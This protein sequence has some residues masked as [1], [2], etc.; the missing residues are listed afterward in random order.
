MPRKRSR[1]LTDAEARIMNVLW[2]LQR[3][4]VGEVVEALPAG[5]APAYNTI[6]TLLRIL[7][8]KGYVAHEKEGRAFIY[9]PLVD[10]RAARQGAIRHLVARLFDG[11]PRL[12]LLNLLE[13][14][15]LDSAELDRLKKL[16]EAR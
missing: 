16:I 8:H 10:R 12:L 15:R 7:E 1:T 4:T 11:S 2:E 6:Q 14:E 3:A 9:R 5:P 13:D